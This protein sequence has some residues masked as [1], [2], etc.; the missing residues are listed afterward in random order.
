MPAEPAAESPSEHHAGSR[1]LGI[2]RLLVHSS[3]MTTPFE[4][5]DPPIASLPDHP[6]S[7]EKS[8]LSIFAFGST[9]S[10]A[11]LSSPDCLFHLIRQDCHC[12][13]TFSGHTDDH[14]HW[15]T[16]RR[17]PSRPTSN[18]DSGI[19]KVIQKFQQKRSEVN[20]E[21]R[22]IRP[23]RSKV[24]C[25]DSLELRQEASQRSR[26]QGCLSRETRMR[27]VGG[28]ARSSSRG[29]A[30]FPWAIGRH[31]DSS[32][33]IIA[34]HFI[35]TQ[36]CRGGV[37]QLAEQRTHKPRV[38]RSIR[39][40]A[41]KQILFR[42]KGQAF[43]TSLRH[44]HLAAGLSPQSNQGSQY[45]ATR[46]QRLLATY[47]IAVSLPGQGICGNNVYIEGFFETLKRE[48]SLI[49]STSHS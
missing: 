32:S 8:S 4:G 31:F 27:C 14:W 3:W 6:C 25:G 26:M 49:A 37:A 41:T 22:E 23:Q 47:G 44:R 15:S 39:V 28:C 16:P 24:P 12:N 46:D 9:T 33:A 45:A 43:T 34:V 1:F 30:G 13:K 2:M 5:R 38:T 40:T 7:R 17:M 18:R 21:T 36:Y 35:S 20:P 10:S 48:S 19:E 29:C 11:S 42:I